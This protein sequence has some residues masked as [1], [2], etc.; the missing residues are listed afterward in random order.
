MLVIAGCGGGGGTLD[1]TESVR[2]AAQMK[3]DDA[4]MELKDA[5]TAGD[6]PAPTQALIG[7]IEEER[8][9]LQEAIDNAA[10]GV[11]T[12]AATELITSSDADLI[13]IR[14]K[15]A[16]LPLPTE[17]TGTTSSTGTTGTTTTGTTTGNNNNNNFRTSFL[18]K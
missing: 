6:I 7:A 2:Q 14:D 8:R 15:F 9:E 18:P 10:P 12:A 17:P 4:V 16:S 11:D 13:R 3:L 1:D 5:V